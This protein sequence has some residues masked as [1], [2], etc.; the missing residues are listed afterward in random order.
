MQ[1]LEAFR[2]T[3]ARAWS[4]VDR[5]GVT[6]SC[7][8]GY[9]ARVTFYHATQICKPGHTGTLEAWLDAL[10][11][12]AAVLNPTL[13]A[14][15]RT[16]RAQGSDLGLISED[17]HTRQPA[18]RSTPKKDPPASLEPVTSEPATSEPVTPE[19]RH[20]IAVAASHVADEVSLKIDTATRALFLDPASDVDRVKAKMRAEFAATG[21]LPTL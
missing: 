21:K 8:L 18:D 16:Q 12:E 2:V 13:G 19:P 1:S 7:G 14:A 11:E 17:T 10:V 15:L 6:A 5:G 3:T 9:M 20:P 4:G